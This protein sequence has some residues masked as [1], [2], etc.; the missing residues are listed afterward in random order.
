MN[1]TKNKKN[2]KI[3]YFINMNYLKIGKNINNSLKKAIFFSKI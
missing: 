3:H 1:P 2:L